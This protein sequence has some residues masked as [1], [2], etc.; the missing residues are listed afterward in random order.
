MLFSTYG[1]TANAGLIATDCNPGNVTD[2]YPAGAC[3]G[4]DVEFNPLVIDPVIDILYADMKHVELDN[5]TFFLDAYNITFNANL[6]LIA[7]FSAPYWGLN[8]FSQRVVQLGFIN[9]DVTNNAVTVLT[10]DGGTPFPLPGDFMI[11]GFQIDL[12]NAQADGWAA[13]TGGTL[14]A[15]LDGSI[16]GTPVVGEWT[17]PEPSTLALFGLGLAGLGFAGRKRN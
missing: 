2:A 12:S 17:V 7:E 8:E 9:Y 15:S 4:I 14:S 5:G 10:T 13:G 6:G 16:T 3:A 1:R 11:H